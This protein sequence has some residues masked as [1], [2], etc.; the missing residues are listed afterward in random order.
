MPRLLR[1][2]ARN[3]RRDAGSQLELHLPR[4]LASRRLHLDDVGAH[5]AEQHAAEGTGHDLGQVDDADALEGA[6][7]DARI[8]LVSH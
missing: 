4:G 6:A 8:A 7:L 1:L 3:G 2:T 5:V